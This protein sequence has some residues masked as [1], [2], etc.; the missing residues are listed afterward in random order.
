MLGI[1]VYAGMVHDE[2]GAPEDTLKLG[3]AV[4]EPLGVLCAVLITGKKPVER[5]DG[6]DR[7]GKR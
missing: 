7:R 5:I 3:T 2:Y 4:E 1:G 6:D